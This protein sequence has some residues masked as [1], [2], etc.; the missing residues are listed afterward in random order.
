MDE[1]STIEIKTCPWCKSR[2]HQKFLVKTYDYTYLT[3]SNSFNYMRCKKCN[4]YYLKNRPSLDTLNIIYPENYST[5]EYKKNLG[6][7]YK[8]KN[9]YSIYKIILIW[10]NSLRYR[11]NKNKSTINIMEVGCG[12]G[13]Y[14]FLLKKYIKLLSGLEV[15]TTGI[16]FNCPKREGIDISISGDISNLKIKENKY[17]LVICYQ[18]IEHVSNPKKVLKK[19]IK[20]LSFSG[21]LIIETPYLNSI[22]ASLIKKSFWAGWHAPRHWVI[23]NPMEIIKYAN[24]LGCRSKLSWTPCPYMWIESI[25]N[26]CSKRI[27]NFFSMSNPILVILFTTIDYSL[28]LI[29]FKTSNINIKIIKK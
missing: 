14:L 25:K 19:M 29:G 4:S 6:F 11:S 7:S 5:Y 8:L 22:D 24:E 9:I 10:W 15:Q 16:D 3:C 18:L 21:T 1:I 28:I 23:L 27:K 2:E 13:D 20:S 17:D 26:L 12:G